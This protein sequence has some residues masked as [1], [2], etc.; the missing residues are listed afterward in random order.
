MMTTRSLPRWRRRYDG[1]AATC[2]S[3]LSSTRNNGPISYP[4]RAGARSLV[5]AS[6]E[7]RGPAAV[8]AS[9]GFY[10][11]AESLFKET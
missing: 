7:A 9:L 8:A 2:R 5:R 6:F 10:V 11:L 3:A 4:L 1:S